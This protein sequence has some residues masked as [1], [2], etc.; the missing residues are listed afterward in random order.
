M[1]PSTRAKGSKPFVDG[2]AASWR[3]AGCGAHIDEGA[4]TSL[5]L[6]ARLDADE[7]GRLVRGWS[8]TQCIEVRQ[9]PGCGKAIAAKRPARER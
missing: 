3:C 6:S 5:R 1:G 4:W 2:R 9:C 8:P 7:V